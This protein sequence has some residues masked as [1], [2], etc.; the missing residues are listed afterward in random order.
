MPRNDIALIIGLIVTLLY[1]V[2]GPGRIGLPRNPRHIGTL[3]VVFVVT[4][5]ITWIVLRL[6]GH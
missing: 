6:V 3:L 4:F 2:G 1:A 5:A